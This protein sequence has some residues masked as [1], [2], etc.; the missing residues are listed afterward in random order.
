MAA[1]ADWS[2][3]T[4]HATTDARLDETITFDHENVPIRFQGGV[5]AIVDL[6]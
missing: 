6:V 5:N 4:V 2:F 1:T 3:F